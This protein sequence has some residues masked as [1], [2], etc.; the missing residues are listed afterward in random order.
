[1]GQR[2]D[3]RLVQGKGKGGPGDEVAQAGAH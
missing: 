3:V 1:V 2:V